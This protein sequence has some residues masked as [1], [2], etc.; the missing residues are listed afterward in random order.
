MNE[1][2]NEEIEYMASGTEDEDY[3]GGDEPITNDD[4][5][6]FMDQE[7]TA[8]HLRSMKDIS[9]TNSEEQEYTIDEK[10]VPQLNFNDDSSKSN[11]GQQSDKE[12]VEEIDENTVYQKDIV[13]RISVS[14]GIAEDELYRRVEEYYL[15]SSLKINDVTEQKKNSEEFLKKALN[16]FADHLEDS[17]S[18]SLSEQIAIKITSAVEN[19]KD[20]KIMTKDDILS[21]KYYSQFKKKVLSAINEWNALIVDNPETIINNGAIVKFFETF[22]IKTLNLKPMDYK[23]ILTKKDGFESFVK[24]IASLHGIENKQSLLQFVKYIEEN[25]ISLRVDDVFIL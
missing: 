1:N 21:Q 14:Y 6:D 23:T 12:E 5:K 20:L 25:S 13:N 15:L 2:N 10:N 3:W 18:D 16:H 8:E 4:V 24:I 11:V 7:I 19:S 17:I 22:D 9:A